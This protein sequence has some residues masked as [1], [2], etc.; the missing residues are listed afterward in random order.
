M[1]AQTWLLNYYWLFLLEYFFSS[2]GGAWSK[3]LCRPY[4]YEHRHQPL[5]HPTATTKHGGWLQ[6]WVVAVGVR[7]W[8]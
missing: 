8:Q 3:R 2:Q 1:N 4:A 6:W 7:G 5:M